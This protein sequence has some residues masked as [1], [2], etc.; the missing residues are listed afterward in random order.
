MKADN[1]EAMARIQQSIDSIEKRMRVDS[2][3][4]DYETHLRQKRQLQQILD[5]MKARNL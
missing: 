5:R 1:T 4:L 3:D 2:N